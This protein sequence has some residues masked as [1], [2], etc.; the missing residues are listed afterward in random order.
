MDSG[1]RGGAPASLVFVLFFFVQALISAALHQNPSARPRPTLPSSGG[2][3]INSNSVLVA[4]LDSHYTELAELVEKAL[5]LQTLE[6]AVGRH[7]LTV[8]APR[9]DALD[10]GIDPEFKRFLLEPR[11]LPSLQTLILF[12]VLPARV[13]SLS[14]PRSSS[15]LPLP[16]LSGEPLHLSLSPGSA[17]RVGGAAVLHPDAI[18]RPDGVIH[19][20]E[21]LLVPAPSRRASTA[22]AASP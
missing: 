18:V 7:N 8:F 20:I 13:G 6:D 2:G 10:R 4:L 21:R 5:L 1:N 15:P 17:M 16:T 11:N 22:A 12:H 19:G 9:N 3:G 14:W